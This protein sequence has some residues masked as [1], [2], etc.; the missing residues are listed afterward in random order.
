MLLLMI[1]KIERLRKNVKG[2]IILKILIPVIMIC[3]VFSVDEHAPASAEKFNLQI[4]KIFT[5]DFG[6]FEK[7]ETKTVMHS[8]GYCS[9]SPL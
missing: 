8:L 6:L 3:H 9:I 4:M 5:F 7:G 1:E 2:N